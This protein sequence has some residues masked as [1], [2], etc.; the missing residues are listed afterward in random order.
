MLVSNC[1]SISLIALPIHIR[2]HTAL[3]HIFKVNPCCYTHFIS[4]YRICYIYWQGNILASVSYISD[5]MMWSKVVVV[6]MRDKITSLITVTKNCTRTFWLL[7]GFL[8]TLSLSDLWVDNIGSDY[9]LGWMPR[10]V[11]CIS[12]CIKRQHVDIT[13]YM[14]LQSFSAN[15][16]Y[17]GWFW[18]ELLEQGNNHRKLR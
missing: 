10:L 6:S 12:G 8:E 18:E 4:E 13:Y 7:H 3:F 2:K 11:V 14:I 17:T 1:L 5:V 15:L 16:G 9:L